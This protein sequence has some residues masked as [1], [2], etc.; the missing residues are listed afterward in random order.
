M[1]GAP[2]NERELP[3]TML[4]DPGTGCHEVSTNRHPRARLHHQVHVMCSDLLTQERLQQRQRPRRL[5]RRHHVARAVHGG[6][7]ESSQA[8]GGGHLK[9]RPEAGNLAV[10]LPRS[11]LLALL[12]GVAQLPDELL[13]AQGGAD[14]VV[15]ARVDHDLQVA[16]LHQLL[17]QRHHRR[18]HV[19]DAVLL[20]DGV[21]AHGP[22]RAALDVDRGLDVRAVQV[23]AHEVFDARLVRP[24]RLERRRP[25]S[26]RSHLGAQDRAAQGPAFVPARRGRGRGALVEVEGV[27]VEAAQDPIHLACDVR[28]GLGGREG[29][30]AARGLVAPPEGRG[31]ELVPPGRAILAVVPVHHVGQGVAEEDTAELGDLARSLP[32]LLGQSGHVVAAVRLGRD[33]K[34]LAGILRVAPEEAEHEAVVVRCGLIVSIGDILRGQG[35]ADPDGLLDEDHVGDLVP[36]EL[37]GVQHL[38]ARTRAEGALLREKAAHARATRAAVG[39]EHHRIVL[40]R[41][42]RLHEP[43]EHLSCA[44]LLIWCR[45]IDVAREHPPGHRGCA[46]QI[47]NLVRERCRGIAFGCDQHNQQRDDER[48]ERQ[49][50]WRAVRGPTQRSA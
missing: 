15:V 37:V 16:R 42:L 45:H 23:G 4:T 35:E 27:G 21:G 48:Q 20:A 10:Q 22:L 40:G 6:E 7:G 12:S 33:E 29:G 17:P 26:L 30:G 38:A 49:H 32:E 14:G 5:R 46:R 28:A 44:F 50:G 25:R 13:A 24:L 41:V 36:R 9:V 2:R 18:V 8:L 43:V 19:V 39:P 34:V 11:P 47:Q 3:E 1:Q 31:Q